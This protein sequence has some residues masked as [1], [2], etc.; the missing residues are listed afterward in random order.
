MRCPKCK[1]FTAAGQPCRR[2]GYHG[3]AVPIDGADISTAEDL[4]DHGKPVMVRCNRA[5]VCKEAGGCTHV[6]D[7]EQERCCATSCAPFGQ[8]DAKCVPI[9]A[10]PAKP[11][12]MMRCEHGESCQFQDCLHLRPHEWMAGCET[13]CIRCG[14]G[15][16]VPKCVPVPTA[17]NTFGPWMA[18]CE[19]K[20][21]RCG[22]GVSVPKCVPVPTAT[23]TFGPGKGI[24]LPDQP[25][26]CAECAK[27]RQQIE[28]AQLESAG[29]LQQCE[30]YETELHKLREELTWA[31]GREGNLHQQIADY[32]T[33]QEAL[34]QDLERVMGERDKAR[35]DAETAVA[36]LAELVE[37]R[38]EA[39]EQAEAW[40]KAYAD[41][42]SD[43]RDARAE[44][45]RE[46][47]AHRAL[48]KLV[49]RLEA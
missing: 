6:E 17:T 9:A 19:T 49:N 22:N 36:E 33:G 14:N 23:N 30:V 4:I 10:E 12:K 18:G 43:E 40:E 38:D 21:I 25:G 27:L 15:V 41:T 47:D 39:R 3:V 1:S 8:P 34:R 11:A 37:E 44:L 46:R 13:K 28:D 32:R 42:C 24:I 29:R 45:A 5:D 20:C 2:C 48:A 26:D 7:H 31:K 35:A 16:S